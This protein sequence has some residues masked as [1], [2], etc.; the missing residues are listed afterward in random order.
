MIP[1]CASTAEVC[2]TYD[3]WY[4]DADDKCIPENRRCDG[5]PHCSDSA[6]EEDC[7]GNINDTKNTTLSE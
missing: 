6:D 5:T 4:C 7:T 2:E 1:Y 3:K